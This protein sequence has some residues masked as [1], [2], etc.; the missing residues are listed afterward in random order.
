MRKD[1]FLISTDSYFLFP[2]LHCFYFIFFALIFSCQTNPKKI[3][4]ESVQKNAST[5]FVSKEQFDRMGLKIGKPEFKTVHQYVKANGLLNIPPQNRA[6]VSSPIGAV[7]K[8]IK[9]VQTQEVKKGQVLAIL[10]HPDFVKLQ[11]DFLSSLSLLGLYEKELERQ[12]QLG[13]IAAQ[14]DVQA[15]ESQLKQLKAKIES[16]K[17]QLII[18][19]SNPEELAKNFQIESTF[20]LLSPISGNIAIINSGIGAFV[21]PETEIF[22][23][24]DNAHIHADM[25][26]F[27]KDIFK[28]KVGQKVKFVLSNLEDK[29]VE[30][31]IFGI[32]KVFE[33]DTKTI[34]VHAEIPHNEKHG[35]IPGMY[36]NA[37][38]EVSS[39]RTITLPDD[40]VAYDGDKI[41]C[42]QLVENDLAGYTFKMYEIQNNS[43][44]EDRF[45]GL[46]PNQD[47]LQNKGFEV[48]SLKKLQQQSNDEQ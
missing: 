38:I 28:I 37:I 21:R 19:N 12:I 6:S 27:E 5:V 30:G 42:F 20:K 3:Y 24:I 39:H 23:I 18:L 16:L 45:A 13:S 41:V 8:Q 44:A 14:R 32:G 11:E 4:A 34:A 31:V 40:A 29:T 7:V 26:V 2:T 36:L 9:V 1:N 22:H 46:N 25:M 43:A 47:Y 35:L 15:A 17:N 33:P 48:L 10:E